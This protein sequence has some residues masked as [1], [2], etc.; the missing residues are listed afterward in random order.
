MSGALCIDVYI[1][2]IYRLVSPFCTEVFHWPVDS[3]IFLC[4]Q[5][6]GTVDLSIYT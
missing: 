3:C 1:F 2:F 5:L 4:K 6:D